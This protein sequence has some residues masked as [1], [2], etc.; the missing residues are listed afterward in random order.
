MALY[1]IETLYQK[2]SSL[3][4][5]GKINLIF[6]KLLG[7]P[8][9]Q[10][11]LRSKKCGR[12]T[13]IPYWITIVVSIFFSRR[14]FS[15]PRV[16]RYHGESLRSPPRKYLMQRIPEIA[17][18]DVSDPEDLIDEGD[19]LPIFLVIFWV[20]THEKWKNDGYG[21]LVRV[22]S[23]RQFWCSNVVKF[24]NHCRGSNPRLLLRLSFDLYL[25][26]KAGNALPVV[27]PNVYQGCVLGVRYHFN[28]RLWLYG[29]VTALMNQP[30]SGQ[31]QLISSDWR[32]WRRTGCV[33]SRKR[34]KKTIWMFLKTVVRLLTIGRLPLTSQID[35][36]AAIY[37]SLEE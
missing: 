17:E 25:D 28:S 14:D 18:V 27:F 24:A 2:I 23:F 30:E 11:Y 15:N 33:G 10:C 20:L 12:K 29:E 16:P 6:S 31:R 22:I 37:W 5:L 1:E 13:D 9:H 26:D 19:G 3:G 4:P 34:S 36:D 8:K 7:R 21:W 35:I 32:P